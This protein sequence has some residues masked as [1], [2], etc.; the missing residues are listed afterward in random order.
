M[1]SNHSNIL[2][3][4]MRSQIESNREFCFKRTPSKSSTV[5]EG[6]GKTITM[7]LGLLHAHD[8]CTKIN[9]ESKMRHRMKNKYTVDKIW[10]FR[11]GFITQPGYD[12]SNVRSDRNKYIE[13]DASGQFFF[14]MPAFTR[15]YMVPNVAEWTVSSFVLF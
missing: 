7:P 1:L 5:M 10:S 13:R 3:T 12:P 4:A 15:A 2:T 9:Q 6:P 8:A 11:K 14:K